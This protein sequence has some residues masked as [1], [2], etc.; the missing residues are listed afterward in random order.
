MRFD[1]FRSSHTC[2]KII[3]KDLKKN[4]DI[5]P[6]MC[7]LMLIKGGQV[8]SE[9]MPFLHHVYLLLFFFANWSICVN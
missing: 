7:H 6:K 4:I 2:A 5:T 3:K 1:P 9:C 8:N